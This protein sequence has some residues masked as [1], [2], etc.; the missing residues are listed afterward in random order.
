[1]LRHKNLTFFSKSPLLRPKIYYHQSSFFATTLNYYQTLGIAQTAT[2]AEIK[3][4]YYRLAKIHHPDVSKGNEEK[5]KEISTA[6]E[7]LNDNYKRQ[8]YNDSLRYNHDSSQNFQWKNSHQQASSKYQARSN[9]FY[10][11]PN[12]EEYW[13]NA[14]RQQYYQSKY[15]QNYSNREY[16]KYSNETSYSYSNW[17]NTWDFDE[18]PKS[19]EYKQYERD[20]EV[21]RQIIF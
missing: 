7:T 6:Y 14:T 4:A 11:A 12:E 8:I 3:A 15:R 16:T 2:Q 9:P 1:M 20:Q 10:G 21:K 17:S 18:V 5:F 13:S 19:E